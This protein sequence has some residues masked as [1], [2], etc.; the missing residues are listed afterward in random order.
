MI[1]PGAVRFLPLAHIRVVD[2]AI[3]AAGCCQAACSRV[4]CVLALA[5]AP[6]VDVVAELI[7]LVEP[8]SSIDK[9]VSLITIRVVLVVEDV[10]LDKVCHGS[11]CVVVRWDWL[12]FSP[13][14]CAGVVVIVRVVGCLVGPS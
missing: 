7:H 12:D 2:D 1:V 3:V 4:L 5:I 11:P 9:I 13:V 10:I 8:G 6:V 14:A